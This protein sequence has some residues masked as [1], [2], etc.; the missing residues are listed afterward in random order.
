MAST[1]AP[2]PRAVTQRELDLQDGVVLVLLDALDEGMRQAHRASAAIELP[3][4]GALAK[5]YRS[6]SGKRSRKGDAGEV[7][8]PVG[9]EDA[10]K[11][12][13]K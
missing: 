12:P 5:R 2:A 11:T 9:G 1:A 4:Y 7:K 3:E 10:P 13:V 8:A 6:R